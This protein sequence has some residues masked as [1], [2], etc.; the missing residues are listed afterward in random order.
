MKEH[1]TPK[2]VFIEGSVPPQKIA[3]SIQ[4]HQKKTGIGAHSIFLGQVRADNIDNKTV[5][6]IEYS[7]YTEMAEKVVHEIREAAF[8]Q[9]D[10]NCM[11]IYH[12]MG[13]V[14][15]GE[16]S[17]MVFTSSPHRQDCTDATK[18]IVEEIKAKAPIYGKENLSDTE[19]TW[20]ENK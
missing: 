5:E 10:L 17:L 6:A 7:A 19:Y 9:F 4:N 18:F 20:K 14:K 1:K 2:K 8:E 16:I 12:S 3:D 13:I 11:H 15:A